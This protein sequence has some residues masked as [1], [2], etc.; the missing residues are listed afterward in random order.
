MASVHPCVNSEFN[1]RI[2]RRMVGGIQCFPVD[3]RILTQD[4]HA[5]R[6]PDVVNGKFLRLIR[7]FARTGPVRIDHRVVVVGTVCGVIIGT[8]IGGFPIVFLQIFPCAGIIPAI[9]I[10]H[11]ENRTLI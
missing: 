2:D 7:C 9:Q 1:I 8:A 6:D 11:K 4:F 3:D 5:L 10:P